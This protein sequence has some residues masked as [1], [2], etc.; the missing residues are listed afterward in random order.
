MRIL[1]VRSLKAGMLAAMCV[2]AFA[3][4]P[5]S[6][7]PGDTMWVSDVRIEGGEEVW[8][9]KEL[10][11]DENGRLHETGNWKYMDSKEVPE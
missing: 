3:G 1:H 9:W 4:T 8:V 6:A 5:V 10:V 2:L 7:A 11:E